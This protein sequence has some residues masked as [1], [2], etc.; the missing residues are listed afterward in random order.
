[1]MVYWIGSTLAL[2]N[3]DESFN[4]LVFSEYA[5]SKLIRTLVPYNFIAIMVFS[6]ALLYLVNNDF[7]DFNFGM[8]AY[9]IVALFIAISIVL[10]IGHRLN[11]SDKARQALEASLESSN[12]ELMLFRDALNESSLVTFT[13]A[14]GVITYVND[15]FCEVSKYSREELVGKTHAITKSGH[16]TTVF[17]NNLWAKISAGKVWVG[18]MKNR[19]KDGSFYWVH[20]VIIPFKDEDGKIYQY[21]AIR[22]DITKV[23]MLSS[24]YESLKL[25]N[26]ETEQFTYIAAHDLQ[27]PLRTVTNMVSVLQED[28]KDKLND[29][30]QQCLEYVMHATSRMSDLIKGLLDYSRIG[31]KKELEIVDFNQTIDILKQDLSLIIKN[32]NTT[33]T[34]HALPTLNAYRVELRL[35]F[36]NLISNA[37]K[38]QKKGNAPKIHISAEQTSEH[39]KISVTDNG[40]GIADKDSRSVFAIFQQLNN[41][42]DYEGTGI[43]LAHCEKIAHLHGGEIW[44]DSKLNEGSTFHFTIS[45]N[46]KP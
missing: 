8:T 28:Y 37:I 21:L 45:N 11:K 36:Q 19:A 20:T 26:K 22:Q 15:K 41:R 5:G 30:A 39:W 43:G 2:K 12:R 13:D 24:Q 38:F 44:V 17:F 7:V 1:V 34:T 9:T 33:I 35:L 31:G 32:T 6:V 23:T 4:N 29:E 10:V 16:H 18:G 14:N 3:A 27:E 42:S 46:L 25:K 40:I